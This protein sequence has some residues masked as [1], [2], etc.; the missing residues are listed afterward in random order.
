M[1]ASEGASAPTISREEHN[2]LLVHHMSILRARRAEVEEARA[3][4]KDAQEELTAAFNAAKADLGRGYSRKYLTALLEDVSAGMRNQLEEERRRASDREALGLPTI[5][6]DLFGEAAAKMPDEARD[7]MQWEAE[8]YLRGRNGV[9]QEIP[10]G[11]PPRFHQA[12]LKG[13]ER[14]QKATQ[15]DLLAAAAAI[16]KRGQAPEPEAPEPESEEV[17]QDLDAAA[18]KLKGAG[19]MEVEPEHEA[20]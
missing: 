14:G 1:P 6:G 20:A 5:Q 19:F 10:D 16:E 2:S 11:C 7:E 12:V 13:Y 3:P 8:G 18:R 15:D 9:L 4:F 17:E